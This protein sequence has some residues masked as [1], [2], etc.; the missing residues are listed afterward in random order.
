[1]CYPNI[2]AVGDQRYT[3]FHFISSTH[4]L[5]L[6]GRSFD[7]YM[8]H[9]LC[10]QTASFLG[11]LCRCLGR[12]SLSNVKYFSF[13]CLFWYYARKGSR[14][15]AKIGE[16]TSLCKNASPFELA[17][18]F[19]CGSKCLWKNSEKFLLHK[20]PAKTPKNSLLGTK[21]PTKRRHGVF[22]QSEARVF[23]FLPFD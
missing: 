16:E 14:K 11:L 9:K 1:M 7:S 20:Q 4:F 13:C 2:F 10:S 17:R 5:V 8:E 15:Q 23:A 22:C 18:N 6:I 21:L 3:F 12:Q 19:S